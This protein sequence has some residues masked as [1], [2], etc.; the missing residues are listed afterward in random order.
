M[1]KLAFLFVLAAARGDSIVRDGGFETFGTWQLNPIQIWCDRWCIVPLT[2][3][4]D[5]H[6]G[7]NFI[8]VSPNLDATI[9]Q[10]YN[11]T[12]LAE[13]Y[14][15][16]NLEFYIRARNTADIKLEV[17]WGSVR[18]NIDWFDVLNQEDDS[19]WMPI[20]MELA[21]V[22][23]SLQFSVETGAESWL[24]LDDVSMQCKMVGMFGHLNALK[25][26]LAVIAILLVFGMFRFLY[27]KNDT[28]NKWMRCRCCPCRRNAK[29]VQL[30]TPE[31]LQEFDPAAELNKSDSE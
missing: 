2:W 28:F 16:C 3:F 27:T 19:Q 6:G 15:T 10:T 31:E 9:S 5:I 14:D 21:G 13:L 7:E 1:Q 17:V 18:Y 11:K 26:S 30:E 29:F 22:S 4:K 12:H 23:S 8:S 24:S 25:I 20:T